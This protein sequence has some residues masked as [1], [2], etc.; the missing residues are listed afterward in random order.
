VFDVNS[1]GVKLALIPST[2][3][4]VSTAGVVLPTAV[5]AR[6]ACPHVSLCC[7]TGCSAVQVVLCHAGRALYAGLWYHAV[8]TLFDAVC[9][10]VVS[11]SLCVAQIALLPCTDSKATAYNTTP[12]QSGNQAIQYTNYLHYAPL[13]ALV[14]GIASSLPSLVLRSMLKQR[15]I[16]M[17]MH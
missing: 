7:Y 5:Y 3:N 9:A 6:L 1:Q 15:R 11:S 2:Y 17:R 10:P 16:L 12:R 4:Y 14:A 8:L 13:Q